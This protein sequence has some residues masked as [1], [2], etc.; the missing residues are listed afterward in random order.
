[1][2]DLLRGVVDSI[3]DDRVILDV[4]GVGYGVFAPSRVLAKLQTGQPTRLHILTH[5]REDHIHLYGFADAAEKDLFVRLTD[6][7]SGVGAKVGMSLLSAFSVEELAAAIAT[8]DV[9]GLTR[10]DGVGKKLAERIVLEMKG[11]VAAGAAVVGGKVVKGAGP[12]GPLADV[13]SA[14]VN[15][16]FKP[17]Q[18]QAA[19]D[20]A[21][22]QNGA[23]AGFAQ[24]LKASLQGLRA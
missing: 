14:L 24:L 1:M 7:V 10:A 21:V 11:K 5:V 12:V 15:M 17:A 9:K 19:V 2:I 22:A 16:G 13:L 4:N 23:D 18:A 8:G 3:T 20:D 6:T